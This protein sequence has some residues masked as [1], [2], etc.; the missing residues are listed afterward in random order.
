MKPGPL[1]EPCIGNGPLPSKDGPDG[2]DR[3]ASVGYEAD[4]QCFPSP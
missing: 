1:F 4:D 3:A 2:D